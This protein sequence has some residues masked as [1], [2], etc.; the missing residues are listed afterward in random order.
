VIPVAAGRYIAGQIPGAQSRAFK[1]IG[2]RLQHMA[3]DEFAQ[4]LRDFIR[5]GQPT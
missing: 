3:R 4:V 1:G 2:H 5:S